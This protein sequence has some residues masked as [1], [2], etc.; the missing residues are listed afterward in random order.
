MDMFHRS[1]RSRVLLGLIPAGDTTELGMRI[2]GEC[3]AALREFRNTFAV[4]SADGQYKL[5]IG[6][7][8][9][10]GD[11]KVMNTLWHMRCLTHKYFCP[12]MFTAKV[13]AGKVTEIECI[14]TNTKD[15]AVSYPTLHTLKNV[16]QTR[17]GTYVVRAERSDI[18]EALRLKQ[19][20]QKFN[21]EKAKGFKHERLLK[22]AKRIAEELDLTW[23]A[24]PEEGSLHVID[25]LHLKIN[26]GKILI[27]NLV[28]NLRIGNNT[29]T[30]EEQFAIVEEY[31]NIPKV[32][33]DIYKEMHSKL[34]SAKPT[35]KLQPH[36]Q[37]RQMNGF[38]RHYGVI[39]PNLHPHFQ[40]CTYRKVLWGCHLGTFYL[41]LQ[42]M[43]LAWRDNFTKG[44]IEAVTRQLADING[45]IL[46]SSIWLAPELMSPSMNI[47]LACWPAL[48]EAFVNR[49]NNVAGD[50]LIT[51][52]L[53]ANEAF[54][55]L[56]KALAKFTGRQTLSLWQLYRLITFYLFYGVTEGLEFAADIRRDEKKKNTNMDWDA[57]FQ[58]FKEN[59]EQLPA[60]NESVMVAN[61]VINWK[62]Y[63]HIS[64][65]TKKLV[66]SDAQ[67]EAVAELNR[68]LALNPD[69]AELSPREE[70][71]EKEK[72]WHS[73]DEKEFE[74]G[75]NSS[76]ASQTNNKTKSKDNGDASQTNNKTK[77]KNNGNGNASQGKSKTKSK[78]NKT[79]SKNN[80]NASQTNNKTKTKNN[81]T[82]SR[83]SGRTTKS[84]NK[85]KSK[86]KQ[87]SA[88]TNSK[89][90][91]NSAASKSR[92]KT[93]KKG[94]KK[95]VAEN[96]TKKNLERQDSV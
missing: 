17:D 59:F 45:R 10:A 60:D 53:Q 86:G 2:Y 81:K 40:K 16:A 7:I 61:D 20:F 95:K 46:G 64:A 39:L 84:Q 19:F 48:N 62:G 5:S 89:S 23:T 87:S 66:E 1:P 18:E 56:L 3:A 54:N 92:S 69:N 15:R 74:G 28:D 72:M 47:Y 6:N 58:T 85:T 41:L 73:E 14:T 32:G 52:Q 94:S 57:A 24:A 68:R 49:D 30:K 82:K 90:K 29:A 43:S 51:A 80:G 38:F 9:L 26:I 42:S 12:N 65:V 11:L 37:G 21:K 79:K 91:T 88:A 83:Q 34:K 71:A 63:D 76:N 67:K 44:T 22:E 4:S 55:A 25:G 31:K 70:D 36:F 13:E 50:G 35:C 33:A 93:N 78:N 96:L 8:S 77:S 75:K 27:R